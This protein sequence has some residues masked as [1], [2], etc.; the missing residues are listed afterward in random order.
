MD[1]DTMKRLAADYDV[2]ARVLKNIPL[3]VLKASK[4]QEDFSDIHHS[5]WTRA[6]FSLSFLHSVAINDDFIFTKDGV[7]LAKMVARNLVR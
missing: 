7:A 4:D 2:Q 5:N 3:A 1:F 6:A